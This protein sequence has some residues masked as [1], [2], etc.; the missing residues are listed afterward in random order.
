MKR[1]IP[2]ILSSFMTITFL[3][4]AHAIGMVVSSSMSNGMGIEGTQSQKQ[5]KEKHTRKHRTA[6][7]KDRPQNEG[8]Q[9]VDK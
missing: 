9:I 2:F 1:A 6:H 3:T 4:P 8:T 7:K 5:L